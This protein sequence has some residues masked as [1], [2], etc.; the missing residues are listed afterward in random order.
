MGSSV[1]RSAGTSGSGLSI[2]VLAV[3][4]GTVGTAQSQSTAGMPAPPGADSTNA[5]RTAKLI[6]YRKTSILGATTHW[7]VFANLN[8]LGHFHNSDF[9]SVEVPEGT[10]ILSADEIHPGFNS[11]SFLPN[12]QTSGTP[13]DGFDWRHVGSADPVEVAQCNEELIKAYAAI[14]AVAHAIHPSQVPVFRVPTAP[15]YFG[16]LK[17]TATPTERLRNWDLAQKQARYQELQS[18]LGAAL[19]LGVQKIL[20]GVETKRYIAAHPDL[21]DQMRLCGTLGSSLDHC[22]DQLRNALKLMNPPTAAL[23]RVSVIAG[24]SYYVRI[25]IGISQCNAHHDA[26]TTE[27]IPDL[28]LVD[29]AVGAKETSKLHPVK[30]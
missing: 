28:R 25:S 30:Y 8:Y 13:C 2:I 23:L 18:A 7:P 24:N 12:L 14:L 22:Y 1:V 17:K 16:A 5:A 19:Y 26:K 10:A 9:A 11:N 3:L 4:T 6:V 15:A 27:C 29:A 21:K 20:D